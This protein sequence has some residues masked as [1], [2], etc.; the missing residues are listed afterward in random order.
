MRGTPS[1]VSKKQVQLMKADRE[2]E[3]EGRGGEE[4]ETEWVDVT[5]ERAEGLSSR[6]HWFLSSALGAP[7]AGVKGLRVRSPKWLTDVMRVRA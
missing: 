3:G 2:E 4:P 7:L 5:S 1:E 6:E